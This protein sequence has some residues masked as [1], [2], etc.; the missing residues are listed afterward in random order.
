MK[1]SKKYRSRRRGRTSSKGKSR[2]KRRTQRRQQR[3]QQRRSR[4]QRKYGGV[5]PP[6]VPQLQDQAE[7]IDFLNYTIEE[8]LTNFS[9][10]IMN[11]VNGSSGRWYKCCYIIE[12][13]MCKM[14]VIASDNDINQS[15][16]IEFAQNLQ[17]KTEEINRDVASRVDYPVPLEILEVNDITME[18]A[19]MMSQNPRFHTFTGYTL[20]EFEE[21][22]GDWDS[23]IHKVIIFRVV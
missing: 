21:E 3:R 19:R 22:L 10:S 6:Q 20:E 15:V 5:A 8:N 17:S 16:M 12:G 11:A 9:H 23:G 2:S 14:Q 7:D 18:Q 13:G 4:M 1:Y